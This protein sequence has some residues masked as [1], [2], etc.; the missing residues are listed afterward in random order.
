MN[1]IALQSAAVAPGCTASQRAPRTLPLPARAAASFA[2]ALLARRVAPRCIRVRAQKLDSKAATTGV[3]GM[4]GSADAAY[5]ECAA[6]LK[7]IGFVNQAELAR[8]VP[9][10]D[11]N[12][13][14]SQVYRSVANA[15]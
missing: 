6:Y 1:C 2:P 9:C 10:P 8:Y 15:V 11:N 12:G 3:R 5:N 4:A 7:S 13:N 14:W